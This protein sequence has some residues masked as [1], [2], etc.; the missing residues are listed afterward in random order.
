MMSIVE[1]D[2]EL[3]MFTSIIIV[4][5]V[6]FNIIYK[7]M[8]YTNS[9][10]CHKSSNSS[11]LTFYYLIISENSRISSFIKIFLPKKKYPI[12]Q[13]SF[14]QDLYKTNEATLYLDSSSKRIDFNG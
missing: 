2:H 11:W 1:Y 4:I 5:S 10:Y 13:I 3:E 7:L 6:Q 9:I 12:L 8:I 14:Q